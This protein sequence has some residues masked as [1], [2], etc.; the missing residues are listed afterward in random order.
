M[1]LSTVALCLGA[2]IEFF[3]LVFKQNV[4]SPFLVAC[5]FSAWIALVEWYTGA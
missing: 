5:V 1:A 3:G 4:K 2:L